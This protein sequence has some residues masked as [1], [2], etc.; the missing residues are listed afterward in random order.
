MLTNT[1]IARKVL[2]CY[3]PSGISKF[4]K[5]FQMF[6]SFVF[7][8]FFRLLREDDFYNT[9][10]DEF[11]ACPTE[12]FDELKFFD[13]SMKFD[14]IFVN[15]TCVNNNCSEGFKELGKLFNK[16]FFSFQ[17]K[18][19]RQKHFKKVVSHSRNLLFAPL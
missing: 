8:V 19:H 15:L 5:D 10:I 2:F 4:K 16:T 13:M 17:F 12:L 6:F 18:A 9:T 11:M 1:V 3:M 7:F 14:N